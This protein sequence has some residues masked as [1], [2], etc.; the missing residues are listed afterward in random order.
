MWSK[1]F[2]DFEYHMLNICWQHKVCSQK[3]RLFFSFCSSS[4]CS[5]F[6]SFWKTQLVARKM[7]SGNSHKF[8]VHRYNLNA[9]GIRYLHA[10][11]KKIKFN[12]SIS[13]WMFK[14]S[15]KPTKNVLFSLFMYL[16]FSL[17]F[18]NL[19]LV[20]VGGCCKT[21]S[22]IFYVQSFRI[23]LREFDESFIITILLFS[24]IYYFS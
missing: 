10:K 21:G 24:I 4:P 20:L 5:L 2:L 23:Q 13:V 12:L 19:F 7:L 11:R 6:L 8:K 3:N 18:P 1:W 14:V 22:A 16:L 9:R 15:T 17:R